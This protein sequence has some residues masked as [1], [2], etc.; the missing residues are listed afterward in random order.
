MILL[1]DQVVKMR[2]GTQTRL[3]DLGG[4]GEPVLF[5]DTQVEVETGEPT[6]DLED[7]VKE[8]ALED[9]TLIGQKTDISFN[10]AAL[11]PTEIAEI[12][13]NTADLK[14]ISIVVKPH[15]NTYFYPDTFVF[16]PY[17]IFR[18]YARDTMKLFLFDTSPFTSGG[19]NPQSTVPYWFWFTK[20]DGKWNVI[21]T[22]A[23]HFYSSGTLLDVF[24]YGR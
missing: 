7:Y 21:Y 6:V 16:I 17:S 4:G 1:G 5:P 10:A 2:D 24:I 14:D 12:L 15:D 20:I 3:K 8:V 9:F 19:G 23:N 11:L 22:G 18:T 13:E